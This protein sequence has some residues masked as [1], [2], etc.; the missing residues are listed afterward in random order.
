MILLSTGAAGSWDLSLT[1]ISKFVDKT[2]LK[3]RTCILY[4]FIIVYAYD[5]PDRS[6]W[7]SCKHLRNSNKVL[8]YIEHISFAWWIENTKTNNKILSSHRWIFI[9]NFCHPEYM[10]PR[11]VKKVC[12]F[13]WGPEAA[14]CNASS[15]T[16]VLQNSCSTK[17]LIEFVIIIFEKHY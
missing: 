1:H 13:I 12:A 15:K 3:Y 8:K 5:M 10:H 7:R 16:G 14:T 11:F 17:F 9:I 2:L 4:R 6:P